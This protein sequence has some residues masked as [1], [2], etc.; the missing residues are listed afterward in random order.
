MFGEELCLDYSSRD[1]DTARSARN[2]DDDEG[3]QGMREGRMK[4]YC[5]DVECRK[6]VF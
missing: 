4:C 2:G 1:S 5:G 6:W 3:S